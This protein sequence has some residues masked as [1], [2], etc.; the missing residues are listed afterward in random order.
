MKD[1]DPKPRSTPRFTRRL[2]K[3]LV[4]AS[5]LDDDPEAEIGTDAVLL[6]ILEEGGGCALWFLEQ[7]GADLPALR[8]SLMK[9]F[10][11]HESQE[12]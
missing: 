11:L 5:H 9:A 10:T 1:E 2:A 12:R 4:I 8:K 3:A 7:A 6:G